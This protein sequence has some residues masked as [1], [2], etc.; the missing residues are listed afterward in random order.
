MQK[1]ESCIMHAIAGRDY[2]KAKRF[3]EKYG[4]ENAYKSYDDILDDEE[5][6]AVY[7][8]LPNH[9]HY[10]WVIKALRKGKN[11]LCEKP[12]AL[13]EKQVRKMFEVA[14]ENNV[15]LMEAFA[16]QHSPFMSEIEQVVKS[17]MIGD[18]RYIETAFLTSDYKDKNI[19]L[20]KEYGGGG[21][22]DLGTYNTSCLLRILGKEP[23]LVMA[24]ADNG[25]GE[26]DYLADAILSYKDGTKASFTCGMVLATGKS[27]RYDRLEIQ[28]TKGAI[29]TRD[30]EYNKE[31]EITY[32]IELFSGE[33]IEK[34]V[35]IPDNYMLEVENFSRAILCLEPQAVTREFSIANARM[36]DSVFSAVADRDKVKEIS[37]LKDNIILGIA[38]L[39]ESRDSSTGDHI[40][41]TKKLVALIVYE[42]MDEKI[43]DMTYMYFKKMIKAA[44]LHDLGKIAIEDCILRKP[45][46]FT[47]EE[48][49]EMKLHTIH[50]GEIIEKVLEGV[51]DDEFLQIAKNMAMYH[52]EKW[53]GTGYPNGLKGEEI[54][55]EARI[56]A[57]ADVY[58][59]LSNKRC[60]KE[61][62]DYETTYNYIMSGM[63]TQFDPAL[64]ECF[65]RVAPI[66]KM[67][68]EELYFS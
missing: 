3:N 30:F 8:P 51:N 66:F 48:F 24:S 6:S 50:G 5:I 11:V 17:G 56:M 68:F 27:K 32:E 59:A 10:E 16:Y 46:R 22:Y 43:Y 45:D 67:Y 47:D 13:S 7:I 9:L 57:L 53:D 4:F 23:E 18:V 58:D 31:G 12:L 28:G 40:K 52:H 15:L 25:N 49:D 39:V 2:E 20:F 37:E 34:K 35:E 63:G 65:E 19:R 54:P 42:L 1:S 26:V 38:E 55:V 14:K 61:G 29:H 36:L 21:I 62:L 41:R 60:Y 64:R 33:R 44:P